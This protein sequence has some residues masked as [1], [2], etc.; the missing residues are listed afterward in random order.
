MVKRRLTGQVSG[1]AGSY[2]NVGAVFYLTVLSMVD[3]HT[4]FYIISA[5][6]AFSFIFC[7]LFLKEPEGAFGE[8]YHM[9]SVDREIEREAGHSS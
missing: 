1:M 2:G 4:F 9:S 6:A 3:S 5:G 8:E 7:F